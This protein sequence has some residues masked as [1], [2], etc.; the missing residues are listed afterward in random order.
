MLIGESI[1]EISQGVGRQYR[2]KDIIADIRNKY[3][4]GIRYDKAWKAR[5]FADNHTYPL[6]FGIDDS[7]NDPSWEWFLKKLHGAIG[8]VDD[9]VV[10]S[11]RHNNIEKA[12]PKVFPHTS[13]DVCT[14]HMKQNF[15][16]KFKNVEIHKLLHNA[17]YTYHLSEFN[18]I[19]GQLQMISPRAATYIIDANVERWAH[20]HST[21]K[22]YNIMTTGI[23][24]SLNVV[25]KDARDLPI[26]QLKCF[27]RPKLHN[28]SF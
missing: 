17:A 2:P 7:E 8:H 11:D 13:H 28:I 22:R 18:V 9:L 15:K 10:V 21:K 12:V 23:A 14:Y 19:F 1:R 16:T 24:E 6:C 26:L 25:L 27:S 5:E 4:V 20:S 3:G